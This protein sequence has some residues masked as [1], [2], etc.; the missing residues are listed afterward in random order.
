MSI[1]LTELSTRHSLLTKQK[2]LHMKEDKMQSS[3][4]KL[5]GWLERTSEKALDG[6]GVEDAITIREDTIRNR[7]EMEKGHGKTAT[8]HCS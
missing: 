4:G 3:S 7:N 6:A 2:N 8:R 5:T 1:F